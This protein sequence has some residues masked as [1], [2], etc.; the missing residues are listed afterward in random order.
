[1]SQSAPPVLFVAFANP[2]NPAGDA[3]LARLQLGQEAQNIYAALEPGEERGGWRFLNGAA[4]KRADLIDSFTTNRIVL[5]HYGGHSNSQGLWLPAESPEKRLVD[6][7]TLD[8]F[9]ASQHSLQLAF[10]NS[11]ENHAWAQ[12]LS[13]SVPYVVATVTPVQDEAAVT[14]SNAF[15]R[16][17][18]QEQNTVENAF[19]IASNAVKLAYQGLFSGSTPQNGAPA[20]PTRSTDELMDDAPPRSNVFPWVLYKNPSAQ[21]WRL[22]DSAADP[23]VGMPS[24]PQRY[25]EN[26]PDCPYVTIKGHTRD[27]AALFFG[28]NDEIRILYD[29]ALSIHPTQPIRLFYGQSG[30][31]KSSLLNAGLLP[32]LGEDIPVVYRRR[33]L[34][35]IDDLHSSIAEVLKVTPPANPDTAWWNSLVQQWLARTDPSLVILDQLEEAITHF[36]KPQNG[37]ETARYK[38]PL[39]EIGAFIARVK[40]IFASL[41][42]GSPARLLLS[43]RKEYLAEISGSFADGE[44]DNSSDLIER[45]WLDRLGAD[46]IAQIVT[47]PADSR[48]TRDKYKIAFPERAQLV[49][50][51]AGE[52][53]RGDSPIAT[54]LEIVL[55]QM[56]KDARLDADGARIYSTDLYKSL[57]GRDNPL[58]GFYDQTMDDLSK[59]KDIPDVS[60]GLE[61]DLLFEHTS[62]YG[63]SIPVPFSTL[64]GKYPDTLDIPKL[65]GANKDLYLLVEPATEPGGSNTAA[66]ETTAL[67]HDTLAHVV[68]HNFLHSPL[69]GPRARRIL[70]GRVQEWQE[71]KSR[72]GAL[73]D[74]FDLKTIRRGL[75]HMRLPTADES[76]LLAAS[77]AA[78]RN[79][80]LRSVLL[81][82]IL[83]VLTIGSIAFYVTNVLGKEQSAINASKAAIDGK[84]Q[85][86][87]IAEGLESVRIQQSDSWWLRMLPSQTLQDNNKG[88]AVNLKA[89]LQ[90]SNVNGVAEVYRET[91]PYSGTTLGACAALLNSNNHPLLVPSGNTLKFDGYPIPD[92]MSE[93]MNVAC[94]PATLTLAFFPNQPGTKYPS[95]NPQ[96]IVTF[97]RNGQSGSI[98]LPANLDAM[99]PSY[100]RLTPG[101]GLLAFTPN[102][103]LNGTFYVMSLS[104]QPPHV[105]A[106]PPQAIQGSSV[107]PTSLITPSGRYLINGGI[108]G[109]IQAIDLSA[110]SH[111]TTTVTPSTADGVTAGALAGEDVVVGS[112]GTDITIYRLS[113]RAHY[114]FGAGSGPRVTGLAISPDGKLIA[115]AAGSSGQVDLWT[116]P[117]SL[118]SESDGGLDSVD[119]ELLNRPKPQNI[120]TQDLLHLAQFTGPVINPVGPQPQYAFSPDSRFLVTVEYQVPVSST[121]DPSLTDKVGTLHIWSV[122][123]PTPEEIKNLDGPLPLFDLGCELVGDFVDDMAATKGAMTSG[124]ENIDYGALSKACKVRKKQMNNMGRAKADDTKIDAAKPG[125]APANDSHPSQRPDTSGGVRKPG[126]KAARPPH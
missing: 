69:P 41:T 11:C 117:S 17:L 89:A 18:S 106:A 74:S 121:V 125:N 102:G 23:L 81:L 2:D 90:L 20:A 9:L 80:I 3:G 113:D 119:K 65:L 86:T 37:D 110:G 31:G 116:F 71:G 84:D 95:Y 70:E 73:L 123:P 57:E 83:P 104:G 10:F 55:N 51:I 85:F 101:A 14:F 5:F 91:L 50:L 120:Y 93:G 67:A 61:L 7:K 92:G 19:E 79:S 122:M 105:A 115:T 107:E 75:V 124:T 39:D 8:G 49:S 21:P 6:G 108:D 112:A 22:T 52:L 46:A 109:G 60:Q 100:P 16:A 15:Y 72:Q 56:W 99:T 28:R 94:D 27:S 103:F 47:G 62:E 96:R 33:N 13:A 111:A 87:A 77:R 82:L 45:F 118:K 44:V 114:E 4:T 59:R 78:R 36:V 58:Q 76:K 88:I 26:L 42:T 66:N 43:F 29:W 25:L 98:A 35:L 12:K 32:R 126:R 34:D 54:V 38:T 48:L 68:R 64:K 40:E 63:T 24:L 30:T 1:M 53:L 97:W